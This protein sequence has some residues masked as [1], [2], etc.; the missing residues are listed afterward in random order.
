V[1]ANIKVLQYIQN[2]YLLTLSLTIMLANCAKQT[3]GMLNL[4]NISVPYFCHNAECFFLH[5]QAVSQI[6]ATILQLCR[7]KS[8]PLAPKTNP[9]SYNE[10]RLFVG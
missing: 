7:V 9:V 8:P 3:V 1:H 2:I 10:V 4:L 5:F 6:V